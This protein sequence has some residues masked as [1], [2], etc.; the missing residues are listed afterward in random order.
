MKKEDLRNAF[1]E[2]NI[3]EEMKDRILEK[4]QNAVS[5]EMKDRRNLQSS[6]KG[7]VK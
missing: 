5:E 3:S 1:D 7:S 2:I 6:Q 4:A